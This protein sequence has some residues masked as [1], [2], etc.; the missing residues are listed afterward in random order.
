MHTGK[1]EKGSKSRSL[2]PH[3]GDL[4]G[5][6]TMGVEGGAPYYSLK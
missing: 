6:G 1:W 2:P 4:A 5:V 3:V